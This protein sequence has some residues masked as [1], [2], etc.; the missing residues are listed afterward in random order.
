MIVSIKYN[1]FYIKVG[2]YG[3]ASHTTM[4]TRFNYLIACALVTHHAVNR[5]P[6]NAEEFLRRVKRL[7][8]FTASPAS[9]LKAPGRDARGAN[10]APL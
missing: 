2:I 10:S 9:D 8:F 6:N 1:I 5:G 3:Q 4:C 7:E